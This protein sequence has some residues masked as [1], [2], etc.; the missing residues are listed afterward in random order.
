MGSRQVSDGLITSYDLTVAG[1][2]DAPDVRKGE[3][4]TDVS[5][6][7]VGGPLLPGGVSVA[8]ADLS[9]DAGGVPGDPIVFTYTVTNT[10]SPPYEGTHAL[11]QDVAIPSLDTG[12]ELAIEPL[13]IAHESYWL[14]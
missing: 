13:S 2:D 5:Y 12:P 10:S 4:I 9:G 14:L 11:Y 3:W 1:P 6:K 7:S 8:S